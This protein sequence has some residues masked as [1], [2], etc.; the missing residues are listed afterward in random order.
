V[1]QMI[2]LVE[3]AASERPATRFVAS[4]AAVVMIA[5]TFLP[6]GTLTIEILGV[7]SPGLDFKGTQIGSDIG[8]IPWGGKDRRNQAKN[9]SGCSAVGVTVGT[10]R[11]PSHARDRSACPRPRN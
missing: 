2:W 1:S 10:S 4:I 11:Q 6:W 9:G 5:G 3:N 8:E 7:R